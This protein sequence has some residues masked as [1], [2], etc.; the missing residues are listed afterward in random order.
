MMV[1]DFYPKNTTPLCLRGFITLFAVTG[2]FLPSSP[3]LLSSFFPP[4]LSSRACRGIF[5]IIGMK[6]L[7]LHSLTFISLRM[8][9]KESAFPP[10]LS[11]FG[12]TEGSLTK[13]K[14]ILRS[15]RRMTM[16]ALSEGAK[17]KCAFDPHPHF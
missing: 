6:I 17:G 3:P 10:F 9:I 13:L 11:S 1:Y 5:L 12:L 14:K 16:R 7:R 8:T 2:L 4:F 15:S